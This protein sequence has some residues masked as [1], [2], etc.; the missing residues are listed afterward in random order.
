MIIHKQPLVQA[1]NGP[2]EYHSVLYYI[3]IS[4]IINQIIYMMG[5]IISGEKPS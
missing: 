3:E 5:H 1:P 2:F 4:N